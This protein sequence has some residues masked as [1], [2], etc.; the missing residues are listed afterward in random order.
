MKRLATGC[1]QASAALRLAPL[2]FAACWSLAAPSPAAAVPITFATFTQ[3][4]PAYNDISFTQTGGGTGATL[5]TNTV[6]GTAVSFEFSNIVAL[7]PAVTGPIDAHMTMSFTTTIPVIDVFA[8]GTDLI[9]YLESGS[10]TFRR[11]SDNAILLQVSVSAG[12]PTVE[13][14]T[15]G[16]AAQFIGSTDVGDTITFSSDFVYFNNVTSQSFAIGLT[17]LIPFIA[18]DGNFLRNFTAASSGSFSSEPPPSVPEPASFAMVVLGGVSGLALRRTMQR[19][20]SA[21]PV[22]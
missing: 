3:K 22:S 11:D 12:Y 7:P 18:K 13:G 10:I 19:T 2:F 9:Q 5:A 20:R 17:S 8:D 15:G 21:E 4:I 14:A 6:G 1:R 16:T